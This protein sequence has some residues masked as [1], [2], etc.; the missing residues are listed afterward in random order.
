MS[1]VSEARSQTFDTNN[2]TL[3]NQDK[4]GQRKLSVELIKKPK[5]EPLQA[6]FSKFQL[7]DK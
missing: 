1:T 6:T 4:G 2:R 3:M 7:S 5:S